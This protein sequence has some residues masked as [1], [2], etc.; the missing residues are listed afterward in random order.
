MTILSA[1]NTRLG[2]VIC[3]VTAGLVMARSASAQV[4]EGTLTGTVTDA[5]TRAPVVDVV[6][7]ATSPN[8]QGEQIVVTDAS[9]FYRVPNLPPGAYTLRFDKEAYK[10]LARD[11]ITL[12]VETTI[13]LN[14]EL[15]PEAL[16]AEEVVV[17]A[18]APTVDVGSSSTGASLNSE[19]T[20]RV[21]V[22]APGGKGS[23][24]RSFEAVAGAAAG[25]VDDTSG[26][27][28]S[29]NGASAAENS[30]LIDG[31]STNNPGFGISGTPL[32]SEFVG[33]INVVTG[34]YLPEYGRSTGGVVSANTKSG[35]NEFHGGAYLNY[36]PGQ[37]EGSRHAV[38]RDAQSVLFQPKLRYEGDIGADLGGPLIKDKLW[39]YA[40]VNVS[41]TA[42]DIQ[43]SVNRLKLDAM[44]MPIVDDKTGFT[45]TEP[46]PGNITHYDAKLSTFQGLGKLTW[47]L[48]SSNRLTL[49]FMALPS[50]SGGTNQFGIN[51]RDGQPE[52]DTAAKEGG[53][54]QSLGHRYQ[55]NP[56][57]TTLRWTTESPK[58][59]L[60]VDTLIGWH[61]QSESFLP[62]D[63][64]QIG[65]KNPNDLSNQPTIQWTNPGHNLPQLDPTLKNGNMC[66]GPAS[67]P[68]LCPVLPQFN[69]NGPG[70]LDAQKYDRYQASSTLTY[71]FSGFG[72]HI[73]KVGFSVE[74][75]DY[76]HTK[77]Y[78]G[79]VQYQEN[80]DGTI[81]D[82]FRFGYLS[83][84]DTPVGLDGSTGR[85]LHT[86]SVIAGG[87]LQDSWSIVDKFT[88][89]L[90]VRYDTQA[91]Y[92]DGGQLG[93]LLPNQWSPRLGA[94]YD[95]TQSGRSK[96]F[97]NYAKY[98]ENVPLDLADV[99]LSGEPHT[100]ASY[101]STC[102]P[103]Q[104]VASPKGCLNDA[105]AVVQGSATNP[106]QKYT[107]F[108]AGASP[109]D[110]NLKPQST[111]EVV[112]GG[113]Y[114]IF[115]DARL[116]LTYTRRWVGDL[117]EDMSRDNL[118]TFFL[119]NPGEGVASDFP[120]AR[121]D[122]DAFALQFVKNFRDNWLLNA[123]YTLSWLRGNIGG[124]I[125][126]D[127]VIIPNHTADF[128][129]KG[130]TINRDGYLPNDHRSSFKVFGAKEWVV[131]AKHHLTGGLALHALSGAPT[132][133]LGRDTDYGLGFAF[134]EQRGTG[135]R[136]PWQYSADITAG[137]RF[138]IN[139]NHVLSVSIDI[140]NFANLQQA[141]DLEQN[142]TTSVVT[143]PAK[144][145]KLS[146]AVYADGADAGKPVQKDV[147][148]YGNPTI[149]TN[150]RTFRFG[151]RWT[152]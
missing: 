59:N 66:N 83:A 103:A 40:G 33:E 113:D 134:L 64:S 28:A 138:A 77:S 63:G 149:Y 74:Y 135:P 10:P 72:H 151:V 20:R 133:A 24:S 42:Y 120:K 45:Q 55:S 100:L 118:Q 78:S 137:Y 7:T 122:Y 108:G 88:L 27:G 70:Q 44:G 48:N 19:F 89:N 92:A 58:K 14:V 85:V 49:T 13:R 65:S 79:N 43:R 15:L 90:G 94:I 142:Y 132:T 18:R 29:I 96:I 123:S 56:Y 67:T 145:G 50:A 121:R 61:R 80:D 31:L 115:H 36:S 69:S 116:A 32:S 128:D 140:Y 93:L 46:V 1:K 22:V 39:F 130:L 150:P 4:G 38:P 144:G 6:V 16:Q 76:A 143:L 87:F 2:L 37:L 119:G 102:S 53:T 131:T 147:K 106:N 114:E 148:N 23:A 26:F 57:D 41:Q 95:P 136:L 129:S 141:S 21:P 152:F 98:Y 99:A 110:P 86:Q 30:F 12:R 3:S 9:G 52:V 104:I 111:H 75:T 60:T 109:V 127:G 105:S 5:A 62:S 125:S 71:L 47:A 81:G 139:K 82:Q 146:D 25:A 124:L 126:Q 112:F 11:G 97:V 34:G 84:P 101:N 8:L 73:A 54:V 51:P 107:A 117:V 17:V 35:T 68:V 91:L